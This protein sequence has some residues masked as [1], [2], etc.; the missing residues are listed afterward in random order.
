[1]FK[2]K[3]C[4]TWNQVRLLHNE[5]ISFGSHT[6]T[7]PQLRALSKREVERELEDS[8]KMI[9]DEIGE[10]IDSFSYP[11][12]FPEEESMLRKYLKKAL[13]K[14]VY[15]YGV[16]TKLGRAS[17][18][19]GPFF[20]KRLPVNSCDDISLFR[21]KLEGGYDWLHGVQ[22]TYKSLKRRS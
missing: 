18:D 1:M 7:H 15:S 10:T 14:Y 9:E 22:Y 12:R 17:R 16:T 8:K 20:L 3:E 19:D 5:G 2:E 11:Y 13:K 6:V 4:L 21:A